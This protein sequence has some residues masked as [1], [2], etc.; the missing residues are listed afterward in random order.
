MRLFP[1]PNHGS[2]DIQFANTN[3]KV[4][5]MIDVAGKLI[6]S[7]TTNDLNLT[8]DLDVSTGVYFL[9][10]TENNSVII[11]KVIVD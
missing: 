3:A 5:R 1:N 7:T 11:E 10:M 8:I 6:Y 2:F 9:E 4:I